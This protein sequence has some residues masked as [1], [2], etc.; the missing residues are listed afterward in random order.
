VLDGPTTEYSP[1][2]PCLTTKVAP[3][4]AACATPDPLC[5]TPVAWL[6]RSGYTR[7]MSVKEIEAA[8]RK[9]PPEDLAEFAAWFEEFQEQLWDEQIARD[10]R[11]GRFEPMIQ[12]AREQF[13]TGQCRTL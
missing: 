12:R 10:V 9:L 6:P 4:G 11:A 8:I 13:K 5:G 7:I 1:E 3:W 2:R